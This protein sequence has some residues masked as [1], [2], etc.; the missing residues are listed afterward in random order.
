MYFAFVSER[1]GSGVADVRCG[2]ATECDRP[3]GVSSCSHQGQHDFRQFLQ[4]DRLP[5]HSCIGESDIRGKG[6]LRAGSCNLW[7]VSL[8]SET[9]CQ[10][11][12]NLDHFVREGTE[13]VRFDGNLQGLGFIGSKSDH[14]IALSVSQS[15]ALLRLDWLM[16]PWRMKIPSSQ[17]FPL[18]ILHWLVGFVKVVTCISCRRQTYPNWSLTKI[19]KLVG[20]STL[21]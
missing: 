3:L 14:C 1:L 17:N 10:I 5:E 13:I 7:N 20:A 6:K 21:N 19:S 8:S 18:L 9:N 4:G 2:D 12:F 16:W 15:V 11:N